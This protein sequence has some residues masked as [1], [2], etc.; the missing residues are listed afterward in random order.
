A[1]SSAS[2]HAAI[3]AHHGRVSNE[4]SWT[5]TRA[6]GTLTVNWPGDVIWMTPPQL[7]ISLEESFRAGMLPMRTVGAP[8]IHGPVVTG[9]H[10]I[11][12]RTP[13]A[14]AVALA[15]VGFASELHMPNGGTLTIG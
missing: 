13:S 6:Y 10:G 8:M 5:T 4:N 11:G 7:Q 2:T 1:R 12:V 3:V 14:A 15:T 9:T